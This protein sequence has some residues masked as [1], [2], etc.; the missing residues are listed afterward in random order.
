MQH[1]CKSYRKTIRLTGS[2][3]IRPL[4]PTY[5]VISE[6]SPSHPV[7]RTAVPPAPLPNAPLPPAPPPPYFK[8]LLPASSA[9]PPIGFAASITP[10]AWT[11]S[12]MPFPFASM[13]AP[14][15]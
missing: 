7:L 15:V 5:V 12:G 13:A 4:L 10:A 9:P 14:I 11:E 1:K 6:D 2:R 8:T 3:V